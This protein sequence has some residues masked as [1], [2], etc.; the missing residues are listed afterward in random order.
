[1]FKDYARVVELVYTADLKSAGR[2]T[3][4]GSSPASGTVTI[5]GDNNG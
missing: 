3:L 4:L 1:M 5:K 2:E